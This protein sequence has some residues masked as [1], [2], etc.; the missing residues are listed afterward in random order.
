MDFALPAAGR[1]LLLLNPMTFCCVPTLR[2][3]SRRIGHPEECRIEESPAGDGAGPP[4]G[5]TFS[6][7]AP[8]RKLKNA[9]QRDWLYHFLPE[10]CVGKM[11]EAYFQRCLQKYVFFVS[12]W[13]D[14]ASV[15]T[16]CKPQMGHSGRTPAATRVFF[17]DLDR[18]T[19]CPAAAPCGVPI[20]GAATLSSTASTA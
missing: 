7:R 16:P 17:A 18:Q 2:N 8:T 19:Q 15:G 20:A 14:L 6:G 4:R 10:S 1:R 9:I 3:G 13:G 5:S 11:P 12:C